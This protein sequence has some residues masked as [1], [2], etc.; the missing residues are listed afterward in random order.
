MQPHGPSVDPQIG[1]FRSRLQHMN[2]FYQ[3][4]A[5]FLGAHSMIR[6]LQALEEEAR[7]R[8]SVVSRVGNRVRH[9]LPRLRGRG[10][11][12]NDSECIVIVVK[13]D[14]VLLRESDRA[15]RED[16]QDL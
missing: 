9:G 6:D 16:D 14:D 2:N 15:P 12:R 13:P 11:H 4:A 5:I 10:R 1:E 3:G 8:R 7:P